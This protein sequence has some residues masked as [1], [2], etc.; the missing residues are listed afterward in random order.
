MKANCKI[1]FQN[2]DFVTLYVADFAKLVE[3]LNLDSRKGPLAQ[4]SPTTAINVNQIVTVEM[5]NETE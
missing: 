5:T 4:L 2:G 1:T 3:G